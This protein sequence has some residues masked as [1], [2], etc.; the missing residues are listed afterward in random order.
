MKKCFT[1]LLSFTAGFTV[2]NGQITT[3]SFTGGLQ[4]YTVPAGVTSLT[5]SAWGAQGGSGAI[6]GGGVAGGVGG[7][8]A[9]AT[10]TLA[11]TPGQ[12]LNIFV[13][14]QGAT[15]TG[16]FNGG[17][18]GGSTNAGGGGGASDIRVGGTAE[19][20]RVLVAGGAGGGGRGG[21]DEGSATTGG[22]GGFGALA[23]AGVGQNGFDSPTSGGV[24]G[25]GKGGNFSAVQGAGGPAGVGCGGFLGA[26]GGTASTGTGANGG[27][28]QTC[29][30]SSSNSIP[31]GGGGGGG[32]IGG[33]GGGG[34]SAGTTGCSGNSKGAGAGGGGGSN[35]LGGVTSGV[36]NDGIW[37][38]NGQVTI[39]VPVMAMSTMGSPILCNGGTTTITVTAMY[40]DGVYTGT[41]TFTVGAGTHVYTVTDG[42][43]GSSTTTIIVTEPSAIVSSAVATNVSCF[44]LSNGAVDVTVSGGTPGYTFLW[45]PGGATTE[46]LTGLAAGTYT[47]VLTD[48]NGC[49]D[50]GPITI[51]QPAVLA[52]VVSTSTNPTTCSGTNG[53]VDIAVTGGTTGYTFLWSNAATTEDLSAVASGSYSVTVTDANG[54]TATTSSVTLTNPAGPTVALVIA[55][56]SVCLSSGVLTLTGGTPAGGTYSGAGVTAGV[57]NPSTAGVGSA[58]ITYSYTDATTLCSA[59]STDV[60]VVDACTGITTYSEAGVINVY[61]NPTN[62]MLYVSTTNGE[63]VITLFDILGNQISKVQST[64]AKTQVDMRNLNSGVYFIRVENNKAVSTVRVVRTK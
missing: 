43:G 57:F 26:P 47:G 49:T 13:G 6:G 39:L 44:G 50:G 29:C 11:V 59:T 1:L 54:C 55:T 21:C 28:G 63:N 37:L 4:T 42:L 46:D 64:S 12:V 32:F 48:A 20:N 19:V 31:G 40:G 30:C 41:G 34:G 14:G 62:G 18:S 36:S 22:I 56:D 17:G 10:G 38:G 52:A 51:T 35:F 53:M 24:A 15:P 60:I 16:G 23:S 58:T 2:V 61:P 3:F 45:S 9:Y 5:V 27:A 25:G 8:G 33:G 7:L